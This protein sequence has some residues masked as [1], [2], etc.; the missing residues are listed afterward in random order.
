MLPTF[1]STVPAGTPVFVASGYPHDDGFVM[2]PFCAGGA[3]ETGDFVGDDVGDGDG[4][5]GAVVRDGEGDGFGLG[6]HTGGTTGSDDGA[7]AVVGAE[8]GADLLC[9]GDDVG[10]GDVGDALG[11]AECDGCGDGFTDGEG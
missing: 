1:L 3:D 8:E 10:R 5:E 6:D 9:V 7:G 4:E 11:R 2:Q